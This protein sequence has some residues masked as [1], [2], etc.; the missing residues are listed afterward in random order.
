[1]L[2]YSCLVGIDTWYKLPESREGGLAGINFLSC[3]GHQQEAEK[4]F[5]P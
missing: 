2:I 1:M 5:E 4:T 3:V